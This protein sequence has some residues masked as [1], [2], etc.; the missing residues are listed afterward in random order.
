MLVNTDLLI[1]VY[2]LARTGLSKHSIAKALNVSYATFGKAYAEKKSVRIAYK[3]GH[4]QAYKT[5]SFK[6]ADIVSFK[7]YVFQSLPAKMQDYWNRI[8]KLSSYYCVKCNTKYEVKPKRCICKSRKFAVRTATEKVEAILTEGGENVRKWLFINALMGNSCFSLSK[9]LAK[10]NVSRHKFEEWV[11]TD[12]DFLQM[13]HHVTEYKK[14]FVEDALMQLV[15]M[16]EPKSVIFACQTLLKDR[17][18][19]LD[20]RNIHNTFNTKI[21]SV[22]NVEDL[23]LPLD[24]RKQILSKIRENNL[25]VA[26][27]TK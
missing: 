21:G 11:K 19:I 7:D 1:K 23:N 27:T 16:L 22:V 9:A 20:E 12:A 14:D 10:V 26:D 18:Y 2:E 24:T 13:I 15:G 3:K 8:D 5:E 17:G 25:L 6:D 4:F